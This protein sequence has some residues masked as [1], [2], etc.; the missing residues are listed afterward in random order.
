MNEAREKGLWLPPLWDD[1]LER[2]DTS[3]LWLLNA[4]DKPAFS[5]ASLPYKNVIFIGDANH[6]VSPFAGAGANLALM[7][8]LGLATSLLDTPSLEE[9]INRYDA[10]ALPRAKRILS[11][12][13]FTIR[14]AHSKGW[15]SWAYMWILRVFYWVF[16]RKYVKMQD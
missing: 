15:M 12:S 8:G 7:D 9:A 10:N 6:A 5:H 11:M 16:M 3:T 1:I 4:M 13:H 14:V 2:T